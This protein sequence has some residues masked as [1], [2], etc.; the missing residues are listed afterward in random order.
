M[1]AVDPEAD[2]PRS[3]DLYDGD[4]DVASVGERLFPVRATWDERRQLAVDISNLA[5]PDLAGVLLLIRN[6]PKPTTLETR[7]LLASEAPVTPWEEQHPRDAMIPRVPGAA[8][9]DAIQ[10][11][12]GFHLDTADLELLRQLRQYVDDCYVPHFVPKENC[13]VC[14]GLWSCGRV[15][16]CGNDACPVRIHEECFGVVL[17]EKL[18]GPWRCPSCLLGHQLMCAVCMQYGG[19]LK[20]LAVPETTSAAATGEQEQKWVHVLCA[21]TIPE[22]VMRDVP[23]MEPV[24]GFE[25]IDNS[26]FRYLCAICR[27]RGGASVICEQDNCN[28]GLHPQCA[29]DAGLMIGNEGNLLGVYCE[30]HLPSSRIPGAKRWI[31]DEDLVEEIMSEYSIDED[32]DDDSLFSPRFGSDAERFAFAL[33]STPYLYC[34]QRL[35]GSTAT[36]HFGPA[37]FSS[38]STVPRDLDSKALAGAKVN[39]NAYAAPAMVVQGMSTQRPMTFPPPPQAAAERRL[40]LPE[41]PQGNAVVGAIVDY[42]PKQQDGWQRARVLEWDAEKKMHLVQVVAS[43]QKLW[44]KLSTDNTLVLYLPD[45]ENVVD[46][47]R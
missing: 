39:T 43:D 16:F 12:C 42:L 17:R 22:L 23:S 2:A 35:L 15:L 11:E 40:S 13:G 34:K 7:E 8:G 1:L 44:A 20:P 18:D 6:F 46:G 45:E 38:D 19:A 4:S 29:A 32:F 25:E 41:F 47:P 37:P 21:L 26:R 28:V 36:L 33:E 27:K 31:S 3:Y 9:S 30:K 14:E 10:L 5:A 24:D